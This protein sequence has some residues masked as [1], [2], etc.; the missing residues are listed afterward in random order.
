M[1]VDPFTPVTLGDI[2]ASSRI[3]MSPMTR[4]R[5][6]LDG[7]PSALMHEYYRQR[8]GAGLII[9]ESTHP[10][11]IGKGQ[12]NS[13]HLTDSRDRTE[14][15]R[16]V[17][18]VHTRGGTIVM[19]LMHSGSAAHPAV[20]GGR[21][22]LAPSAVVPRPQTLLD[23]R[24]VDHPMPRAMT[25]TEI[26]LTVEQFAHAARMAVDAGFDGVEIHA[27]NG[28]LLHQFLASGT[29]TRDDTYGG[30]APNRARFP[31]QVFEAVAGEVGHQRTALRISP[32][33]SANRIHE[34]DTAQTHLALLAHPGV[35]R[36]AYVHTVAGSH[37]DVL[38]WI[39]SSW[40]GGWVDN[41]GTAPDQ[42]STQVL[43][44]LTTHL[45]SGPSAVSVGRLFI[46]NPDLPDRLL[47]RAPLTTPDPASFYGGDAT[48]YTDYTP[49][50]YQ[51]D[52]ETTRV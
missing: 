45:G 13:P 41:M 47:R 29:N 2:T 8:A 24:L 31:A 37:P 11:L 21:Q 3:V 34:D 39:R 43:N 51:T 28:Y 23:G 49:W 36:A 18:A 35:Q 4:R 42:N 14:W 1:S 46:S 50:D 52:R 7:T 40:P 17:D 20:N 10:A 16:I 19:Q 15:A 9:T 44:Q 38:D 5:A 27:G 25:P 26:D 32:G 12:P 6:H 30:S 33:Q 48:G 22:P